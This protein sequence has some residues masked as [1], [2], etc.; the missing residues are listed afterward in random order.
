L[1]WNASPML[2]AIAKSR[3]K[4]LVE[5]YENFIRDLFLQAKNRHVDKWPEWQESYDHEFQTWNNIL[6]AGM[7]KPDRIFNY[8]GNDIE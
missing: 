1:T 8:Q 7:F 6:Q 2:Q 5:L 4:Q 3:S